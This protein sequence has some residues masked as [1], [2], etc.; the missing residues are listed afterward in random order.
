M[1]LYQ[2]MTKDFKLKFVIKDNENILDELA[3]YFKKNF[4]SLKDKLGHI[5][6]IYHPDGENRPIATIPF[7][8]GNNIIDKDYAIESIQALFNIDEI[9]AEELLLKHALSKGRRK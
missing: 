1:K 6:F 7:L 2:I 5:I 8:F 4:E 9:E 3:K